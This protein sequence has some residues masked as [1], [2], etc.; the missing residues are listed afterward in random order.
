M[1]YLLAGLLLL[2]LS[3]A[4]PKSAKQ[5]DGGTLLPQLSQ[6]PGVVVA[7]AEPLS[8]SYPE[9]VMF[10]THAVLPMPGGPKLLNP[11]AQFLK[12]HPQ[13]P[14]QVDI[15]VQTIYGAEYDQ[16]LAEKRGELLASYL[17]SKGVTLQSLYFQPSVTDGDPLVFTLI[18][19]EPKTE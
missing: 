15:R 7:S 18:N 6:L 13:L 2:L 17:L 8:F 14:W 1:R 10:G 5:V 4:P 19:T 11:L 3:C 12:Q 9:Q 16:L